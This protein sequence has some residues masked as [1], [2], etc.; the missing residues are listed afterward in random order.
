MGA[1]ISH[2]I[3]QYNFKFAKKKDFKIIKCIFSLG[4]YQKGQSDVS[5]IYIFKI[6]KHFV[7][8]NINNLSLRDL[9]MIKKSA[10]IKILK[11]WIRNI[12]RVNLLR[13]F[14]VIFNIIYL[15]LKT[16]SK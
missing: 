16:T 9:K 11:I 1:R 6:L 12:N 2:K 14:Q 15:E 10:L 5:I 8:Q 3:I 4:K 13:L 7:I